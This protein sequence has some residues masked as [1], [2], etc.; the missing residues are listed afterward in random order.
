MSD[1]TPEPAATCENCAAPLAG[2]YCAQCGQSRHNP[3]K[4]LGHAIEEVF[5]SFWHLDGRVFRTLRDL[6]V[7]GRVAR[8]YL[9]GHRVRYIPP[10][11]LFVILSLLTFF[12]GRMVLPN[13]MPEARLQLDD[14]MRQAASV[15]E[16][17]RQR[18]A[19][20]ADI[21]QVLRNHAAAGRVDAA[22]LG[23]RDAVRARIDAAA[24][25]R[26]AELEGRAPPSAPPPPVDRAQSD[27]M[28][29]SGFK[30]NDRPWH[31]VANPLDVAWLPPLGDQWLNARIGKLR[32]NVKRI[33]TDTAQYLLAF[34]GAVPTALILLMP[35]F[36]LLLKVVYLGT[37]RG[38]LEHLVVALYS[39][40]FLLLALLL[41]FLL[42]P[43]AGRSGGWGTL[44]TLGLSATW[45]FVPAYLLAMQWRV[46]GGHWAL[47][48]LRYA[49]IGVVYMV[50][51]S[52]AVTYAVLAGLSS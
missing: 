35:V 17:E 24:T 43:L 26:V 25:R 20:L 33:G 10:L 22:L 12:V 14:S 51:V 38:Y 40:A 46:Y 45:L 50:L 49:L 27:L 4:H 30:T 21:E 36:A 44:G 37:G 41:T 3:L 18:A 1:T 28:I 52:L 23:A 42:A 6:W 29:E 34:L 11:R 9:A 5:E 31:P 48:L 32:E 8:A 2:R 16:V 13:E 15:A 39:H 7:P 19:S 47:V